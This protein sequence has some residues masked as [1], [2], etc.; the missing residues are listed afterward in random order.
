MWFLFKI[1]TKSEEYMSKNKETSE[2]LVQSVV[3]RNKQYSLNQLEETIKM[4]E[5]YNTPDDRKAEYFNICAQHLGRIARE[6][7]EIILSDEVIREGKKNCMFPKCLVTIA[8]ISVKFYGKNIDS[9]LDEFHL[10]Y[11]TESQSENTI[12]ITQQHNTDQIES[13]KTNYRNI[14]DILNECK[15]ISSEQIG[16]DIANFL[17]WRINI[18]RELDSK[19]QDTAFTQYKQNYSQELFQRAFNIAKAAYN[20]DHFADSLKILIKYGATECALIYDAVKH[21]R[22]EQWDHDMEYIRNQQYGFGTITGIM[23]YPLD[24]KEIESEVKDDNVN[25]FDINNSGTHWKFDIKRGKKQHDDSMCNILKMQQ[26]LTFPKEIE[27]SDNEVDDVFSYFYDS[28]FIQQILTFPKETEQSDNEMRD[29]LSYFYDEDFMKTSVYRTFPDVARDVDSVM[30]EQHITFI[31]K[32][33][34]IMS[35]FDNIS[36]N[37]GATEIAQQIL[38]GSDELPLTCSFESLFSTDTD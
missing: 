14:T 1:Q 33:P 5:Q 31:K 3:F 34:T 24:D 12:R 22:G 16:E 10:L 32:H 36:D 11:E 28:N 19:T 18:E 20:F 35:S 30:L 37:T 17:V 23:I 9:M 21:L 25:L 27:Q 15:K 13:S 8:K 29:A 4:I 7:N 6:R 38:D 2:F 26:T